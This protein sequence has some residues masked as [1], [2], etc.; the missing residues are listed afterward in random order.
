MS[1]SVSKAIKKGRYIYV[2]EPLAKFNADTLHKIYY[3]ISICS[4]FIAYSHSFD[5]KNPSKEYK[6]G[7][8]FTGN[9]LAMI[10]S[11]K[12]SRSEKSFNTKLNTNEIENK[13]NEFMI[14]LSKKISLLLQCWLR[15]WLW[16]YIHWIYHLTKET[17]LLL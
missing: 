7:I 9:N 3:I 13:S 12:K 4:I 14:F 6:D 11:N 10:K 1:V 15:R 2:V 8:F 16:N 17:F 5:H